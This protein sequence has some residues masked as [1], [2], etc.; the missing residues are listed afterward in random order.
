MFGTDGAA[1]HVLLAP[2]AMPPRLRRWFRQALPESRPCVHRRRGRRSEAR[3]R[4]RLS[5]QASTCQSREA[6]RGTPSERLAAGTHGPGPSQRPRFRLD[7]VRLAWPSSFAL[8]HEEIRR[9]R[10]SL[11]DDPP[12]PLPS[13]GPCGNCES[14]STIAFVSLPVEKPISKPARR[15]CAK[16]PL[17]VLAPGSKTGLTSSPSEVGDQP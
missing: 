17:M 8:R 3:A 4:Y 5:A 11:G 10:A 6:R 13:A 15:T 12:W 2:T 16:Y 7:R 14:T 1:E 9:P